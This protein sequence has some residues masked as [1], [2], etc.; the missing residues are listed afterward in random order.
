VF[1]LLIIDPFD[2]Y[3]ELLAEVCT[4][5]GLV[6]V[7]SFRALDT[8]A[9]ATWAPVAALVAMSVLRDGRT[10][11]RELRSSVPSLRYIVG[12]TNEPFGSG[13]LECNR[14][15]VK[16]FDPRAVLVHIAQHIGDHSASA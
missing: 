16:P 8:E 13:G 3:R 12:M 11:V 2:D 9:L 7:R 5:S 4:A 14:V 10:S 6:E 1:R 15:V